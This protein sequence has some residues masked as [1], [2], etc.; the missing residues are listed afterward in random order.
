MRQ[1]GGMK[2]I[3]LFIGS[4]F[5]WSGSA[6]GQDDISEVGSFD[7]YFDSGL[8][9]EFVSHRQCEQH[10]R[11]RALFNYQLFLEY[12]RILGILNEIIDQDPDAGTCGNFN[13]G[14]EGFLYKPIRDGGGTPV[15]LLPRDG[16]CDGSESLISNQRIVSKATGEVVSSVRFRHCNRANAGRNHQDV[17]KLAPEIAEAGPVKFVFEKGGVEECYLIPD[18]TK[19]YD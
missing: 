16:Y 9:N 12:Q 19:R 13:D 4:V 17:A 10:A 5:I 18:A 2:A 8:K 6:Y 11:E 7:I 15:I 3:L 1:W 14:R